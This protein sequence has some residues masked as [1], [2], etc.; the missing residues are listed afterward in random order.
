MRFLAISIS[1]VV[2]LGIAAGMLYFWGMGRVFPK[3]EHSFF[4]GPRPILV[5][6]WSFENA[7]VTNKNAI[8]WAD[9][10]ANSKDSLLV[11]PW[12]EN[13]KNLKTRDDFPSLDRPLLVDLFRK[14]PG[15]K[16]ILNIVSNTTN[17]HAQILDVAKEMIQKKNIA[18]QSEY[19]IVIRA[20]KESFSDLPYGSSQ[21]DRLRFNAFQSLAPWPGGLLPATSFRGDFYFAPLVWRK[22][23]MMS[24]DIVNELHRRQ[25][26]ILLGPLFSKSDLE[27]AQ[28]L[29]VDGYLVGDESLTTLHVA[30]ESLS[31]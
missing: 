27:R 22:I 21:S 14:Y 26:I 25:K 11:G 1:T 23:P 7:L 20:T 12:G 9:I 28:S 17:I 3:Y 4:E 8:L 10:Y 2:F 31:D 13:E 19:D 5:V 16:F 6:P 18:I 15:R 30:P 24:P 29:G